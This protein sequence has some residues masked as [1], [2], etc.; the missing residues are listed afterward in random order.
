[1]H[2]GKD[3]PEHKKVEMY[4]DGWKMREVIETNIE[5]NDNEHIETIE[6]ETLDGT[7]NGRNF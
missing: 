7:R 5:Q 6:E 3:I 1:M 2:I 4:V